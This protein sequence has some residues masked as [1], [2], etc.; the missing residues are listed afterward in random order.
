MR[1]LFCLVGTVGHHADIEKNV[2]SANNVFGWV[3]FVEQHSENKMLLSAGLYH[4]RKRGH[5]RFVI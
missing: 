4:L 3:I 1:P 2:D 5:R